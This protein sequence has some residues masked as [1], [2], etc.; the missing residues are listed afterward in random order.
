[1]NDY[2]TWGGSANRSK[3]I[4]GL[5]FYGYEWPTASTG[6]PSSTTG[7]G[8]SMTYDVAR[9]NAAAHGRLWDGA[10][11]TP[12]Y[13]SSSGGVRQGWYDDAESLGHKWDLV[14]A[15]D[16]GGTGIWALNY[17][18]G[19]DLLWDAL[20]ARFAA[21]PP[22]SLDCSASA[23]ES[24]EAG[25]S[26][27]FASSATPSGCEGPVRFAWD[28]GDGLA[29]GTANPGHAYASAGIYDW[30][31]TASAGTAQCRRTG[32][33]VVVGATPS[34]RTSFLPSSAFRAG[35]NLAEF[36]TD[37]RILNRGFLPV[38]VTATLYD[39]ATG[40]AVP[41]EPFEVPA[42]SQVPFDNALASLFG[43]TLE[44]GA[45]GPIRFESTGPIVVSS[46]VNN[47]NACGSGATS[48]Q[49]LPGLEA[50]SAS[51][52]SALP[53]LAVSPDEATGYRTNLVVVNPGA[54][55]ATATVRVRA[56]DGALLSTATIGP[57]PPNGFRQVALDDP[58]VFPG[59]A[60]RRDANL[61]AEVAGDAPVLAYASVIHNG[62]GDPFA[63]VASPDEGVAGAGSWFLP[64]SAFRAGKNL[65]EFRTDVR[66]L[67]LGAEPVTVTPTLYDQ[68]AG[69]VVTAAPFPV[70]ARSQASFD[71]ALASLFGRTLAQGAFGPIRFESTGP[72]VVSSSVNNVNACGNG[73]TSGQWL[74]GLDAREAMEAGVIPQLAVSSVES[75]GYRTNLVVVN[76][77]SSDVTVSVNVRAGDGALL[78]GATIGPLPPNGFRQVALDDPA[79][80]PGVAG[81][82]DANLWVELSGGR[83]HLAYASVIHNASG[84]PFAVV[85]RATR[86]EPSP[87][88]AASAGR[89]SRTSPPR[90]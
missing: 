52:A 17:N 30:S 31:F 75:A 53:Q 51:R 61:W 20:R 35:K 79:V 84:D 29:S 64:S 44:Q 15:N 22:C 37:V 3:L 76:P 28:F 86:P 50:G 89:R 82:T 77:S 23:P 60:G 74:P 14:A 16:L 88:A 58:A 32:R 71:N 45:F 73:A 57:L 81:R 10:S 59:I 24:G 49:W 27:P 85:P 33:V 87:G 62:S 42:R 56:G 48:G 25:V 12:Y 7:A 21:P 1:V 47:V 9:V 83:F 80:F 2:L 69:E 4:L 38:T 36:R 70:P 63:V 39:Q 19:D 34:T 67:N 54:S 13:V 55:S 43:R 40:A 66:L 6:V 11:L 90:P 26:L 46:S 8:I 41:A 78:S 5:P 68:A 72:I 18:T 65:A